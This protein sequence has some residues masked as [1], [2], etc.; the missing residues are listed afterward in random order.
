M[1][2][3]RAPETSISRL[4][5]QPAHVRPADGLVDLYDDSA[6]ATGVPAI[7][8]ATLLPARVQAVEPGDVLIS[9][10][11]AASRRAWI[12]TASPRPKAAT[13]DW[14][15]MRSRD[16]ESRYLRQ[17]LVSNAFHLHVRRATQSRPPARTRLTKALLAGIA[18][19]CPPVD[20][21]ARIAAVVDRADAMRA[22]RAATFVHLETL[23]YALF[24]D[25]FGEAAR[26]AHGWPLEPF[27]SLC[28][29]PPSVGIAKAAT[30]PG[31]W[32]A[33]QADAV[34]SGQLQ[35]VARKYVDLDRESAARY[36]I[37][38]G[39]VLLIQSGAW[40]NEL[41]RAAI[42]NP[43]PAL[44][45]YHARLF[46][47]RFNPALVLP[48]YACYW[49][50]SREARHAIGGI[51][52][53]AGARFSIPVR[54]LGRVRMRVPPIELQQVFVRHLARR[55]ALRARAAASARSLDELLSVLRDRAFRGELALP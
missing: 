28:V 50:A 39:D 26:P 1:T 34:A 52:R 53:R 3:D 24:E 35:A 19:P 27:A 4:A 47:L 49:L 21:Q 45:A 38:D 20:E 40:P 17:L 2:G 18:I 15:I 22:R 31:Q 51:V 5:V 54:L 42:A 29:V 8:A 43:G 16:F 30:A 44:W 10:S 37:E 25:M 23:G 14:L 48:E 9:R 11:I 6:F 46:R 41:G 32:L 13:L 7:I 33:M 12:V 36:G 55:D